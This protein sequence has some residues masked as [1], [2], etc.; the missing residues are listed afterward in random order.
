VIDKLH[1]DQ[2]W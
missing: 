1:M 2:I